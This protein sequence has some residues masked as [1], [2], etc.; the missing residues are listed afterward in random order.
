MIS[1]AAGK[2][3][4]PTSFMRAIHGS[5]KDDG[6]LLIETPNVDTAD[7]RW[8]KESLPLDLAA[9][10]RAKEQADEDLKYYVEVEGPLSEKGSRISVEQARYSLETQGLH[11]ALEAQYQE[12]AAASE[13][14]LEG[15]N[16]FLEKR[17]PDFSD[18]P[19]LP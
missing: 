9:A 11:D 16:A 17:D 18:S 5:L 13:D 4:A 1:E 15:V 2:T 10:L 8:F 19:W 6:Y 3:R 14:Y 12:I 7:F